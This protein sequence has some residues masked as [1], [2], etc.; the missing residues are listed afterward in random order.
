MSQRPRCLWALLLLSAVAF[1]QSKPVHGSGCIRA[2]VEQGCLVLKDTK[3][4]KEFSL[5]FPTEGSNASVGQAISFTG[6]VRMDVCQQ[7]T[8][9]KVTK[10]KIVRM[11]CANDEGSAG[12]PASSNV[13]LATVYKADGTLQCGQ[14]H[15]VSLATMEKELTGASITVHSR[16]KDT[17]GM[18]HAQVCGAPTGS[19]NAYQI[20]ASDKD[21]A[22]KLGFHVKATQVN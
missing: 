17:D 11:H 5:H 6:T 7:G 1:A 9:V 18:L 22:V 15:E 14:G 2:G 13:K 3:T 12:S 4:A 19:V 21:K 16:T 8:A 20:S 10:F